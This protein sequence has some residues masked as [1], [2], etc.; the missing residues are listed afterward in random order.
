MK[1]FQYLTCCVHSTAELINDMVDIE[2]T[3]TWKTFSKY[4]DVK[5]VQ[6]LFPYYTYKKEKHNPDTKELTSGFHIKDDW[7]VGFHKSKY[8]GYPCYY[9]SHSAIEYI[10]VDYS[11]YSDE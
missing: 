4:V 2:R 5:E 7:A 3:I 1:K 11:N 8:N 10:F 9:I 6:Q